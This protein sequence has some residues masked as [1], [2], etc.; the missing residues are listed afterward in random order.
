MDNLLIENCHKERNK[1][2]FIGKD[3]LRKG[4]DLVYNA[5]VYLQ[6]NLM[7]EAELYIIGPSDAPMDFDNPNVYFLGNLPANKVQYY[8]NLCDV[9]VLPSRFEAF[10]IVFVE[11][12]CYGL[13]CIGR[14]LMEMPNLIQNNETGLLL[15]AEEE[16]PQVLAEKMYSLITNE[17]FFRNVQSKQEY[18]KVEY[19]WDTVA[20]RMISIMKQDLNQM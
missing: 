6:N 14:N 8:Y 10:G 2:L 16:N 19:S 20:K 1:F 15:S 9:F 18:Y 17:K 12:L 7:P 11:A 3:F 13:P 5:F 4:G